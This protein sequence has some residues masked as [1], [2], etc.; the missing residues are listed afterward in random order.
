MPDEVLKQMIKSYMATPQPMYS[1]GWQGGEPT[2]MGV[3]FFQKVVDFQQRYGRS[4]ARVGNGLQT[5]ATLITDDMA[6]LFGKY[7]FLVGCSLDGPPEVHDRYRRDAGGKAS[8]T[9][10]LRGLE[11][12]KRHHVE[13]N[14]LVLVSQ[15]N[16]ARAREVYRYLVDAGYLFHQYIPCVEFDAA[17]NLLPFAIT[18]EE[19]GNFLCEL[20]DEWYQTGTTKVSIRHFDSILSKMVDGVNTMCVMGDNCCQYFVVE[21]N[22]DI[23][24]CDFFVEDSLKIGNVM[25]TSW[26]EALNSPIYK[27]FGA[28]KAQWNAA[29]DT[30]EFLGLC[31]AD[32]LK[33]RLYADNPPHTLGWL[34]AGWKQFFSYTQERFQRLAERVRRQRMREQRRMQAQQRLYRSPTPKSPEQKPDF[35]GVG[36]NDPC[37]CGSGRKFKKCCGA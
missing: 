19:W 3:E 35:K 12:L 17:G 33:H 28:Q 37:P 27:K 32:C 15:S 10:V 2:L 4:G 20:F 23:Y 30:C 7:H 9:N 5:N 11:T 1:I 16:I 22:G 25:D 14:I 13:F 8:H 26:E 34:C 18:G 29:C 6:S 21:H 36:R 31:G 24:P